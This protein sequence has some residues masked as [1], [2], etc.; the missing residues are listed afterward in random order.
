MA[1]GEV[2]LVKNT[3]HEIATH[4]YAI[5]MGLQN[6][7]PPQEVNKP[8]DT[9]QYLMDIAKQLEQTN[10]TIEEWVFSRNK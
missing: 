10:R 2:Q 5:A 6:A 1:P 4:S 8:A 3:L 9:V 7:A